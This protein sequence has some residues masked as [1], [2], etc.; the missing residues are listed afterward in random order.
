MIV[1]N[2]I[3]PGFN[4]DPSVCKGHDG[5][6]IA[7]STF[8]WYPGITIYYSKDMISWEIKGQPLK[9]MDRVNLMG[10]PDSGGLWAP[11]LTY[12]DGRYWLVITDVKNARF[13]KD[14]LNYIMS[15]ETIDGQW[16][17]P[18][19][20]NASGFDPALFHDPTN[21]KK[22]FLN[23]LWDHR[24]DQPNFHGILLQ[25]IDLKNFK[26]IGKS[27]NIYQGTPYNVTEGSQIIYKEGYY[28][29]ICAE[30]G[31]GYRHSTTVLRSKEV[32]GPYEK[33]PYWP[34]LT[35]EFNPEHSL[36]KAGHGSLV[37][38]DRSWYLVFLCSRPLKERGYCQ[39]GRET[40]IAKVEWDNG[41]PKLS[42]GTYLPPETVDITDLSGKCHSKP[43]L[44]LS[45]LSTLEDFDSERLPAY[46]LSLR[47]PLGNKASL[48]DRPGYLRL[49][50]RQS[51]RSTFSQALLARR[52][53]SRTFVAETKLS[54]SP[55]N[56][57][58]MAGII[59]YYNTENWMYLYM[60]Y[61]ENL[62]RRVLGILVADLDVF[63]DP[64]DGAYICIEEDI[65]DVVLGVDVIEERLN[66]YYRECDDMDKKYIGPTLA[67]DHL[68]DDYI[69]KKKLVF[70]GAMVGICAQDLAGGGSYAEFDY[71]N[72]IEC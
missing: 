41:W 53:Q 61:D 4:P 38:V 37:E 66:F 34:L 28:Y 51:L 56:F 8:E 45:G 57:Q 32:I 60:T 21:G 58:Q 9:N 2:P 68:S 62:K 17:E 30:N 44:Q 64:L 67:A 43:V 49:Y 71:F 1:K 48:S 52:W 15:S 47:G 14:T 7:T 12:A 23:M 29:L 55:D 63:S 3:L 59:C 16:S 46:F 10:N 70:T 40:A 20:I 27:V 25:E 31:T 5:Y 22:Y 18:V 24:I 11:H 65:K 35:S 6:Y 69:E 50:G 33:S 13:F 36:Q 42:H 54:F 72:Y 39:L 26:L 19:F